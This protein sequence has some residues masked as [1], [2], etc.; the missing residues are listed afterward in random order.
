MTKRIG[1]ALLLLSLALT[2][3]C[4]DGG[5]AA[6]P[7]AAPVAPDAAAP[8]VIDPPPP[9]GGYQLTTDEYTVEPGQER[10]LCYTFYSPADREIAITKVE[11]VNGVSVHHV[12]LFQS[13]LY[14]E[15]DGFHE[16]PELV[17]T[18]WQPIW[19]G[20]A[21]G[22]SLTLPDGVAF[23]I[24]PSTQY[25]VQFHLQNTGDAPVT[26]RSAIN[27]TD[28]GDATAYEPAGIFAIGSFNLNIPT[29]AM[30]FQQI[31]ECNA[32]RQMNVFAAFP[33]MHKLGTKLSF[34]TGATV[35]TAAE[36]YKIDPW[37]FGDQ[38]MDPVDFS[39][40]SGDFM[41]ATCHWDNTTGAPVVFGESS[42]NEMCFMILF[43]W[44]MHDLGGCV[45]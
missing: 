39:I 13:F 35:D 41:R 19:A 28:G 2:A 1:S 45:N 15:P 43:Y 37:K 20:G 17:R 38:P 22:A 31:L 10:Y 12:A 8:V 40:T 30:D 32:D 16:C 24:A 3:A 21:G 4:T 42:D 36:A 25:V 11:P 7:D 34:D 29:G 23:R 6:S 14:P 44:P 9:A 5:T 33:H 18:N 26:E 27:L